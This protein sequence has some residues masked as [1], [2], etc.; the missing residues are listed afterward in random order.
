MGTK[1]ANSFVRYTP[2]DIAMLFATVRVAFT[3]AHIAHLVKVANCHGLRVCVATAAEMQRI[4]SPRPAGCTKTAAEIE[5]AERN[6]LSTGRCPRWLK[7]RFDASFK[8]LCPWAGTKSQDRRH[9]ASKLPA[10]QKS[11]GQKAPA[12]RSTGKQT[13]LPPG[14]RTSAGSASR[15]ATL[16]RSSRPATPGNFPRRRGPARPAHNVPRKPPGVPAP[17]AARASWTPPR[18][19]PLF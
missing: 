10:P 12:L 3:R 1:S 7:K 19:V 6:Y 17:P 16:R 13:T 11:P 4:L 8:R 15:P 2:Y 9:V 14:S 18:L 5:R